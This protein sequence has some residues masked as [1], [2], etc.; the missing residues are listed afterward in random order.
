MAYSAI[1]TEVFAQFILV[2]LIILS[3]H[4]YLCKLQ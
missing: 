3:A 4:Y 1:D 2:T